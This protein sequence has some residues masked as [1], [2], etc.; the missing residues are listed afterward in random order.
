M[1]GLCTLYSTVD[2]SRTRN[3]TIEILDESK[4]IKEKIESHR[5]KSKMAASEEIHED[6][7]YDNDDDSTTA[8]I[9]IICLGD[10]AVGKSK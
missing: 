9:K 4:L 1:H 5:R 8:K 10:S 6:F 7:D 3:K 2:K